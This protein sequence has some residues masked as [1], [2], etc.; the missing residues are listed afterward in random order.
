MD[1]DYSEKDNTKIGEVVE[2]LGLP[3]DCWRECEL[4]QA[5]GKRL[6]VSTRVEHWHTL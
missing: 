1:K 2:Q 3:I 4:E 5:L 6:V